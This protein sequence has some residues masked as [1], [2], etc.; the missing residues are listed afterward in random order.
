MLNSAYKL[1]FTNGALLRSEAIAVAEVYMKLRSWDAVSQHIVEHNT[2]DARTARSLKILTRELRYR[3]Q[4]LSDEELE[5][6]IAA[7]VTSQNHLLWIASARAYGFIRDFAIEV[8]HERFITFAM[9]LPRETFDEFC[10]QK[11]TMHPELLDIS[12]NTLHKLRQVLFL[13]MRQAGFLGTDNRIHTCLINLQLASLLRE[14]RQNDFVLFPV[15]E[16]DYA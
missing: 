7:D 9:D 2:L 15:F 16:G 14:S 13:M 10:S 4:T 1:S 8:L 5:F 12:D 3:L 11:S 6:L